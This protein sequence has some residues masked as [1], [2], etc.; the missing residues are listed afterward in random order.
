MADDALCPAVE[1]TREADFL[2]D[3]HLEDFIRIFVHEWATADHHFVDED[4]QAVPVNCFTMT[5]IE[6]YLR[7]KV[8]RR[9]TES[10]GSLSWHQLL[11]E[12]EV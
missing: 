7:G 3:N 12:S 11:N 9:S 4:A 6:Y 5:L 10:I 2:R 1:R 8:L